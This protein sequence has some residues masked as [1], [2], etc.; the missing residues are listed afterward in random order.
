MAR[1]QVWHTP[2]VCFG[3]RISTFH[4]VHMTLRF[5]KSVTSLFCSLVLTPTLQNPKLLFMLLRVR[6][7]Q[8]FLVTNQVQLFSLVQ[9]AHKDLIMPMVSFCYTGCGLFYKYDVPL[10]Y[11]TSSLWKDEYLDVG[12]FHF[13]LRQ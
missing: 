7:M 6:D 2:F 13:D 4:P 1:P 11:F 5:M 9:F 10:Y 8:L 3:V 12:P